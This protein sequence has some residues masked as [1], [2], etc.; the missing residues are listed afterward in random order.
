MNSAIRRYG[1]KFYAKRTILE[2]FPKQID[3]YIEPFFGSG[4][5]FFNLKSAGIR[6][7]TSCYLNDLDQNIAAVWKC[8]YDQK[9]FKS[10]ISKIENYALY[11]EAVFNHIIDTKP[12]SLV[13]KAF[14]FMMRNM[15][16]FQGRNDSYYI[17]INDVGRRNAKIYELKGYWKKWHDYLREFNVK[18]SNVD[19]SKFLTGYFNRKQSF[20]Y[21]DP[22]YYMTKGYKKLNFTSEDHEVLLEHL[23]KFKGRFALTL[24]NV[25]WVRENYSE[26]EII[27]ISTRYCANA[28]SKSNRGVKDLLIINYELKNNNAGIKA[29]SNPKLTEFIKGGRA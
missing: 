11:S 10:L 25:D 16:S 21:L 3:D 9:L 29:A 27:E 22:P 17:G 20:V 19:Y 18:I 1:G 13:E 4:V 5:I 12:S 15:M 28:H 14:F 2:H 24:N 8:F 6:V 26:F 7:K 23:K